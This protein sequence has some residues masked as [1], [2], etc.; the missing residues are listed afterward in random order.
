MRQVA[1]ELETLK[2]TESAINLSPSLSSVLPQR[3]IVNSNRNLVPLA[4]TVQP[5][6]DFK[7]NIQPLT[8]LSNLKTKTQSIST[9]ND[10][11]VLLSEDIT[12]KTGNFSRNF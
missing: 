8:N 1:N 5:I 2:L 12:K 4:H 11:N 3:R 7:N 9:V 6:Q 10:S